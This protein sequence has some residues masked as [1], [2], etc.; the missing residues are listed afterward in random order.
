M[1][2]M[3]AIRTQTCL[4]DLAER[5]V[6]EYAGALP[7]GRIMRLVPATASRLRLAGIRGGGLVESTEASVRAELTILVG[8]TLGNRPARSAS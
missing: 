3:E 7:P 1:A 4:R 5:L 6:C 8:R 2:P